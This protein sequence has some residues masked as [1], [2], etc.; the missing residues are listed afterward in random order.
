MSARD[1]GW[2]STSRDSGGIRTGLRL[3][4]LHWDEGVAQTLEAIPASQGWEPEGWVTVIQ[5]DHSVVL[6][7]GASQHRPYIWDQ[8]VS[9]VRRTTPLRTP[10]AP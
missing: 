2:G 8:K 9:G 4:G 5:M 7:T 6:I 3:R 10:S 1:A